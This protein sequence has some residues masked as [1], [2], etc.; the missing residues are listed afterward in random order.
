MHP[1]ECDH[2][3]EGGGQGISSSQLDSFFL[4]EVPCSCT[5]SSFM[6]EWL[7]VPSVAGLDS[8]AHP[9]VCLA[10]AGCCSESVP[11]S[12]ALSASSSWSHCRPPP[13][14]SC[15][16]EEMNSEL[17]LRRGEGGAFLG[18]VWSLDLNL[19]ILPIEL[20]LL[21]FRPD[22][23]VCASWLSPVT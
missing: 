17:A 10:L 21:T 20:I 7:V 18:S 19:G 9:V 2:K 14:F 12:S 5:R 15:V 13:S 8:K 3:G 22:T 11:L 23:R 1:G 6:L 16:L 4:P